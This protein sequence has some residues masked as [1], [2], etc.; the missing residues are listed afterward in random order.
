MLSVGDLR[1]AIRAEFCQPLEKQR[2]EGNCSVIIMNVL[3][4]IE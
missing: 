3:S 2:K 4:S 1:L